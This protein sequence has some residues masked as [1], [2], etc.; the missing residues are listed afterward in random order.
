MD[1]LPLTK[2]LEELKKT[3]ATKAERAAI[4]NDVV[5]KAFDA[6]QRGAIINLSDLMASAEELHAEN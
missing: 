5:A 3:G 6:A 2:R 4:H 1:K